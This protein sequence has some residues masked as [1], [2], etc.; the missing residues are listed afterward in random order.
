MQRKDLGQ[1]HLYVPT[2]D[3]PACGGGSEPPPLQQKRPKR[4]ARGGQ[5]TSH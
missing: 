1:R 3:A 5:G 4:A 2:F